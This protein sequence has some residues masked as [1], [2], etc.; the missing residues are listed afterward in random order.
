MAGATAGVA[1]KATI[2]SVRVLDEN[3][4][5]TIGTLIDGLNFVA[6]SNLTRRIASMSLGGGY[7]EALND[8]VEGAVKAGVLT[9]VAAGNEA[10]DA[11][12]VS[13]GELVGWL[14]LGAADS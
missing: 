13:P 11:C 12:Q 1:K 8:A 10:T 9:I 3:G 6:N 4:S 2:F 7:A 5:G 14:L